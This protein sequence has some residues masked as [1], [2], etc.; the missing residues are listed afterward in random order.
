MDYHIVY[1]TSLPYGLLI[2]LLVELMAGRNRNISKE[3]SVMTRR[4]HK[5]PSR[6][7]YEAEHPTV[8][9]RIPRELK[10]KLADL[11][12][13]TGKSLGDILREAVAVQTPSAKEAF[14]RGVEAAE[15]VYKIVYRC[16]VCGEDEEVFGAMEKGAAAELLTKAGWGHRR[17][18]A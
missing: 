13:I 1:H 6:A 14:D 9:I 7:R 4:P 8:S 11:W 15:D 2:M 3:V 16:S 17:C 5:A 10:E 12:A 18:L